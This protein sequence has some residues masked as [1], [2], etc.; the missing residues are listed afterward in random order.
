MKR[1]L[2]LSLIT[3]LSVQLSVGWA[4]NVYW[5]FLDNKAGTTFDPYSYFDVKAIE[6]YISCGADL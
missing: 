4:Q 3:I 6:R 2:V 5:V 1:L